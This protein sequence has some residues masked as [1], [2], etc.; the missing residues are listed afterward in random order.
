MLFATPTFR[1]AVLGRLSEWQCAAI[2]TAWGFILLLPSSTYEHSPAWEA[3]SVWISEPALGMIVMI[4]GL[5]RFM[6]LAANG[7]WRPMYYLRA[8]SA[9]IACAIWSTLTFGFLSTGFVGAWLAFYPILAIF[10]AVN[11]YRAMDDAKHMEI[12]RMASRGAA[13]HAPHSA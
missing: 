3:F 1:H 4:L 5:S 8:L 9:I 12:A 6:I 11:C 10:A 13:I 2:L 7:Y